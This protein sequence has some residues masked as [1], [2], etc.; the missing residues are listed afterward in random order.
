MEIDSGNKLK[1]MLKDTITIA[2]ENEDIISYLKVNVKE[3]ETSKEVLNMQLLQQRDENT[4]LRDENIELSVK[5]SVKLKT[6]IDLGNKLKILSK[7]KQELDNKLKILS[8]EKQDEVTM[9]NVSTELPEAMI[10]TPNTRYKVTPTPNTRYKVTPTEKIPTP[11]SGGDPPWRIIGHKYLGDRIL[12]PTPPAFLT[13][14]EMDDVVGVHKSIGTVAG[15]ISSKD[16]DIDGVPGFKSE[17]TGKLIP[18]DLFHVIFD[19][20]SIL[21]YQDLEEY[22]LMKYRVDKRLPPVKRRILFKDDESTSKLENYRNDHNNRIKTS[23]DADKYGR[24]LGH[25][26]R[27]S[28]TSASSSDSSQLPRLQNHIPSS[29][30]PQSPSIESSITSPSSSLENDLS[31]QQSTSLNP[32]LENDVVSS[33]LP[34]SDPIL[35][36]DVVFSKSPPSDIFKEHDTFKTWFDDNKCAIGISHLNCFGVEDYSNILELQILKKFDKNEYEWV[37]NFL[38]DRSISKNIIG[39]QKLSRNRLIALMMHYKKR[40]QNEYIA[41]I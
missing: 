25:N 2:D 36:N 24:E 11:K 27:N 30:S 14:E 5:L 6:E 41:E 22:E 28:Q 1:V 35:E 15:W 33:K 20:S 9:L 29:S 12:Y 23:L 7:E 38:K 39:D 21:D 17:R 4:K 3:L 32:I 40:R 18:A 26:S 37:N 31:S 8:K 16:V 10:P 19:D 34:P 13:N